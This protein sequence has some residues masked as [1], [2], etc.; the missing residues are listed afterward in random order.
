M[1]EICALEVLL[2]NFILY[3]ICTSQSTISKNSELEEKIDRTLT[4]AS[5]NN[6][7]K[8]CVIIYAKC[9]KGIVNLY[10]KSESE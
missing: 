4:N 3:T 2:F 6:G 7:I 5:W 8:L 9:K 1:E 10:P